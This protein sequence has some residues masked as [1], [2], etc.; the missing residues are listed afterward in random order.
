MT[1]ICMDSHKK[2]IRM[3][4]PVTIGWLIIF[5]E[6]VWDN[7]MTSHGNWNGMNIKGNQWINWILDLLYMNKLNIYNQWK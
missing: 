6:Y 3:V 4:Y 2:S 1:G 7:R 5:M